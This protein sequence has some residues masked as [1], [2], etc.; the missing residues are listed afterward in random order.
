MIFNWSAQWRRPSAA[1]GLQRLTPRLIVTI[2]LALGAQAAL[3]QFEPP[4]SGTTI[5]KT[6]TVALR[7]TIP[8]SCVA[9][10]LGKV[11]VLLDRVELKQ[12]AQKEASGPSKDMEDLINVGDTGS[13]SCAEVTPAQGSGKA[14]LF[15]EALRQ[16]R[17]V[18][19]DRAERKT[20]PVVLIRY[21]GDENFGGHVFYYLPDHSAFHTRIWWRR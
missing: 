15:E 14:Y 20:V 3:A 6:Y 13:S 11:R 21:S 5:D 16:G 18:V 12:Q 17:A 2:L 10:D 7:T 1:L 9:L 4:R 19:L 8:S